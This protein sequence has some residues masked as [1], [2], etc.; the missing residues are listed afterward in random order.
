MKE[1]FVHL[2]VMNVFSHLSVC[3]EVPKSNSRT[4]NPTYQGRFP[5]IFSEILE[6]RIKINYLKFLLHVFQFNVVNF[7]IRSFMAHSLFQNKFS[8]QRDL[9]RPLSNHTIFSSP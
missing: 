4:A 3:L 8:K 6:Y 2:L 9:V 1:L 5:L 7:E